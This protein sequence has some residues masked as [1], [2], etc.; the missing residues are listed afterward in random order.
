MTSSLSSTLHVAHWSKDVASIVDVPQDAPKLVLY[1]LDGHFPVDEWIW[2]WWGNE[3]LLERLVHHFVWLCC[4]L[5]RWQHPILDWICDVWTLEHDVLDEAGPLEDEYGFFMMEHLPMMMD[6]ACWSWVPFEVSLIPFNERDAHL[7]H[8]ITLFS[9][10]STCVEA[11]MLC[12]W[13]EMAIFEV[14]VWPC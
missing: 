12:F 8:G 2:W 3:T 11:F 4:L 6:V 1:P 9:P 14:S 13:V 10:L 5:S 7:K